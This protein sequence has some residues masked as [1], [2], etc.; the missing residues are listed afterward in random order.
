MK[1]YVIIEESSAVGKKMRIA[2]LVA[3]PY[4]FVVNH[5]DGHWFSSTDSILIMGI[6]FHNVR[7][8]LEEF[9]RGIVPMLTFNHSKLDRRNIK[10]INEYS[11][12]FEG[13]CL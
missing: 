1:F 11:F 13:C 4:N 5:L 8:I 10:V 7:V 2:I 3:E 12:N 6:T 9:Q